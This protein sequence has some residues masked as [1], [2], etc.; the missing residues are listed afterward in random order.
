MLKL[1]EEFVPRGFEKSE[2][3]ICEELF[4]KSLGVN[5]NFTFC[6]CQHHASD[7]KLEK[8]NRVET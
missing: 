8:N 2:E 6:L 3:Q 1:Q 4:K 7:S 5:K